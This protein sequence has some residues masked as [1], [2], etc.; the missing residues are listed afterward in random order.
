MIVEEE[1]SYLYGRGISLDIPFGRNI[2]LKY[3]SLN[4]FNNIKINNIKYNCNNLNDI[5][6][7]KI[8]SLNDSIN[9]SINN[10][11]L[12]SIVRQNIYKWLINYYNIYRN[13]VSKYNPI[14]NHL[15]NEKGK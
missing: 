11:Y 4:Y 10:I 12:E 15:I 1:L 3:S 9:I 5:E 8:L 7:P 13:K 14:N 6:I 2:L